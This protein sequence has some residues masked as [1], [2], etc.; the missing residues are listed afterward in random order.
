MAISPAESALRRGKRWMPVTMTKIAAN[1]L[2]DETTAG[3]G[4]SSQ[5]SAQ[6][7]NMPMRMLGSSVR[8]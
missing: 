3:M 2:E 1:R 7:P 4:L 8:L 6:P 5:P